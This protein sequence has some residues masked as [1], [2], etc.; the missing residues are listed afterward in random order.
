MFFVLLLKAIDCFESAY[1]EPTSEEFAFTAHFKS[2]A[3]NP[4]RSGRPPHSRTAIDQEALDTAEEQH[5]RNFMILLCG[6]TVLII[7]CGMG[8]YF[9]CTNIIDDEQDPEYTRAIVDDQNFQ[10]SSLDPN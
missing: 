2:T 9:Y 1:P 5:Q 6:F 3:T 8:I 4:Q 7:C 10:F